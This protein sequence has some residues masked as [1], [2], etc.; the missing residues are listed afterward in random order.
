MFCGKIIMDFNPRPPHGGRLCPACNRKAKIGFQSTP[1]SRRATPGRHWGHAGLQFQSTPSSRRATDIFIAFAISVKNF[2]PRPPH[3][4]RPLPP[5]HQPPATSNFNPRPPHG[6][7]QDVGVDQPN[8]V[9]FQSTPSSRRATAF[10]TSESPVTS[11]F[12]STPSSRRATWSRRWRSSAA[13]ISI[14][15]LLTEGDMFAR[16]AAAP[17]SHFNP[18]PPHGGRLPSHSYSK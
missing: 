14:H 12:Q 17:T 6:G 3:G 4:G 5:P 15:A 13:C 2:N 1:S 18:R 16:S 7:R 10:R 8:P 9:L 11:L